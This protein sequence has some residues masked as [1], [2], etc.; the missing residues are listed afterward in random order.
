MLVLHTHRRRAHMFRSELSV[1]LEQL[2]L[3]EGQDMAL[4]SAEELFTGAIWSD[5]LVNHP[6][7]ADGLLEVLQHVLTKVV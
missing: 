7:L 3:M 1:P 4:V 6:P 5:R 2:Q